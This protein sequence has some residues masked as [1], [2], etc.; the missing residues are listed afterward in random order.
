MYQKGCDG[1]LAQCRE[2]EVANKV[3]KEVMQAAVL[4]LRNTGLNGINMTDGIA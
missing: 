2:T 3:V 1:K 4:G